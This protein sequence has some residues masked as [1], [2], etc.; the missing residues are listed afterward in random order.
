VDRVATEKSKIVLR[1]DLKP[2]LKKWEDKTQTFG[3]FCKPGNNDS[4]GANYL[5]LARC[6]HLACDAEETSVINT[7]RLRFCYVLWYR[8]Y[9]FCVGTIGTQ[10]DIYTVISMSIQQA[11]ISKLSEKDIRDK[12]VNWVKYGERFELLIQDLGGPD[13]LFLLP[14]EY[15]E[16]L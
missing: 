4:A 10:H 5:F 13:V 15:G 3:A 8:F 14:F 7:L 9:Q 2:Y 12:L 11:G 1:P 6:F 16:I